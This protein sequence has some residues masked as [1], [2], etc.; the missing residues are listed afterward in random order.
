MNKE[1]HGET[2]LKEY[3]LIQQELMRKITCSPYLYSVD[4]T[5]G[6]S[7]S[8]TRQM[9]SQPCTQLLPEQGCESGTSNRTAHHNNTKLLDLRGF[10]DENKSAMLSKGYDKNLQLVDGKCVFMTLY[11]ALVL[12][13]G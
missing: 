9:A 7:P 2:F 1:N 5:I 4:V 6:E 11:S 13:F 3:P 8:T 10:M 12:L